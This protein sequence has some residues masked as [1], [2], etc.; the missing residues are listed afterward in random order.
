[1][2]KLWGNS[3]DNLNHWYL[4]AMHIIIVTGFVFG[5][6]L[7]NYSIFT[8]YYFCDTAM[9]E[10]WRCVRGVQRPVQGSVCLS[11]TVSTCAALC[12][13]GSVCLSLPVS[14]CAALCI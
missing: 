9:R 3:M 14:T 11:L 7:S 2:A 1:M 4:F 5:A 6:S 10:A 13:Q 12:V 8:S